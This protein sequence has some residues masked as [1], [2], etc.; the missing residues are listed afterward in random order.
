MS[1]GA[2]EKA[3]ALDSRL[4]GNDG[5]GSGATALPADDGVPTST[6]SSPALYGDCA[7]GL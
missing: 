4:R 6:G 5:I 3:K 1:H 7:H 2:R